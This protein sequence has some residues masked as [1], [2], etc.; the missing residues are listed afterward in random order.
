MILIWNRFESGDFDFDF[1][2]LFSPWFWFQ[3]VLKMILPNNGH[4][5]ASI[6]DNL[7]KTRHSLQ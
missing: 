5:H 4:E 2:S 6:S 3:I 1:K 7:T